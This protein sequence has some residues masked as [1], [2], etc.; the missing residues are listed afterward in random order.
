YKDKKELQK[1][2]YKLAIKKLPF[3]ERTRK[4]FL[5]RCPSILPDLFERNF[6]KYQAQAIDKKNVK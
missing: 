3:L 4:M 2:L 5:G 6:Q 1:S